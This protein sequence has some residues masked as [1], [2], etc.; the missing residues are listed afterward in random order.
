M[1]EIIRDLLLSELERLQ[2]RTLE[3]ISEFTEEQLTW[4]PGQSLGN[5]IGFLLWHM[6]RRE[7]Y[8]LQERIRGV[9]QIWQSEGWHQRIGL[10]PEATGFGFTPEQVNSF[11][12][13][14]LEQAIAYYNGVREATL[15]YLWAATD[16]KLLV[17]MP[18]MPDTSIATYLMPR[19]GHEHEH[20]GQIDYLKGIMPK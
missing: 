20:W 5:P 10:D 18:D 6:S 11:N 13:P 17:T 9:P 8:H 14:S 16:E 19:I 15:G 2:K 4:L 3:T 1:A 7:D 12:A